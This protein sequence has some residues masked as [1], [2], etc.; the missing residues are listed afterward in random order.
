M[1][2]WHH[3]FKGYEFEQTLRDSAG[4]GSLAC[5]RP[6]GYKQLD[7]TER[8]NNRKSVVCHQCS[9]T[10]AVGKGND[11]LHMAKSMFQLSLF[12]L[13]LIFGSSAPFHK[14]NHLPQ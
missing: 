6:R 12:Q 5:C 3:R 13:P 4:Q 14:L 1:V 8:L 10:P 9:I 11:N 7:M 2:G